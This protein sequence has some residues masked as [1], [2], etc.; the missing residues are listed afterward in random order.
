VVLDSIVSATGQL[1][2]YQCPLVSENGVREEQYPFLRGRP[3]TFADI[4]A[5]MVEPPFPTLLA[6][7]AGYLLCDGGPAL[8]TESSHQPNQQ[9]VFLLAP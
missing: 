8:S 9:L 4:W 3:F 7:P 1:L 2:G 5:E 6:H